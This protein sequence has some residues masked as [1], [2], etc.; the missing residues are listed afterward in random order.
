MLHSHLSKSP[1]IIAWRGRLLCYNGDEVEG[2]K[3]LQQALNLDPDNIMIKNSIK[4]IK[5]SS[6]LKD[7][8]TNLFKENKLE[9]A[10]QKFK[11][12][13][14]I[15]DLN[16]HYNATICLNIGIALNKKN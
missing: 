5:K 12:C 13:L 9:Q 1:V 2:K 7:E 10:I 8:A 16:I 4:N 3:V 14:E 6:D 11:E 15:D